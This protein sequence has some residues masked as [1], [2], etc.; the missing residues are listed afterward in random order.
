M[1]RLYVNQRGESRGIA[2]GE[3][4]QHIVC[5][6]KSGLDQL[7]REIVSLIQKRV[8]ELELSFDPFHQ[9][10]SCPAKTS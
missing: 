6:D 1:N 8:P 5:G 7:S 2:N 4:V 9:E 3:V 10:A